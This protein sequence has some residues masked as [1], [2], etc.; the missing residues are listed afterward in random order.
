MGVDD[1]M[2]VLSLPNCTDICPLQTLISA[3]I[4]LIPQDSRSL[5][6]WSTENLMEMED[7]S[8]KKEFNSSNDNGLISSQSKSLIFILILFYVAF[9]F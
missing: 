3:T 2:I 4:D 7:L 9:N 8:G 5:C 1:M 6:G